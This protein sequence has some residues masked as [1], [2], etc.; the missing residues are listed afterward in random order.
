MRFPELDDVAAVETVLVEATDVEVGERLVEARM[1]DVSLP[2]STKKRGVDVMGASVAP[3]TIAD[4][5]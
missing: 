5:T 3:F 2:S 4:T 1:Q